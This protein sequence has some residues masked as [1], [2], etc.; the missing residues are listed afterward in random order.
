MIAARDRCI[1]RSGDL[2]CQ[3]LAR[4][5]AKERKKRRVPRVRTLTQEHGGCKKRP[6]GYG[7]ERASVKR[8]RK[9]ERRRGRRR[10]ARGRNALRIKC[11]RLVVQ[12]SRG[13]F[14]TE[15]HRKLGKIRSATTSRSRDDFD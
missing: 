9:R 1:I 6:R 10:I 11:V 14:A 5:A 3:L 8:E 2:R 13:R 15:F 12:L 4:A 7:S